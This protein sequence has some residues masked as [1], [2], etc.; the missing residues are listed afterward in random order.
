MKTLL[1]LSLILAVVAHGEAPRACA[2]NGQPSPACRTCEWCKYC[3]R[4]DGRSKNT[5]T[6]TVCVVKRAA[7]Q[8]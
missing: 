2:G 6:C 5:G 8:R 1:R 4:K 3:G 7:E